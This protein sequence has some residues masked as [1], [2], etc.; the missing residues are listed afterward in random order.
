[1]MQRIRIS[2]LSCWVVQKY[3]ERPLVILGKKFD[4]RQWVVIT[5]VNPLT[6]WI[7]R[8]P[9]LRFTSQDYNPNNARNK[10][11]HLTNA[12]VS[13]DDKNGQKDRVRGSHVIRNNMWESH[14]M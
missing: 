12:T 8:T 6:I 10:F 9:Y 1:M 13:K 7:W 14:Q 3:I 2:N 11:Q 5:S 4:I